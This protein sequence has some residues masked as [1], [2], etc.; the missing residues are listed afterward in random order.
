MEQQWLKLVDYGDF[1]HADGIQRVTYDAA[2]EMQKRFRSL[3]ARLARKFG[4]IPIY[5]GHPDDRHF[6]HLPGHHDT[7]SYAWVQDLEAREDGIWILPKWSAAGEEI[8]KNAFFK[9]LSPRW[10]MKR[11]GDVLVPIR[12]ISVGLTNHPNIPGE[13]I[14][15]AQEEPE[16]ATKSLEKTLGI[17]LQEP[18][19]PEKIVQSVEALQEANQDLQAESD[20]FYKLACEQEAKIKELTAAL[21]EAKIAS[22][23]HFVKFALERGLILPDEVDAWKERYIADPKTASNELLGQSLLNTHSKTE[24][25][26]RESVDP[27]AQILKRVQERMQIT[28][29][30]YT[31]AWHFV[32][33]GTPAF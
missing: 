8:L 3:R 25:L 21:M 27:R 12:L 1:P 7:R 32:R 24:H 15:N 10:E 4:G 29:E 19:W 31:A 22:G 13:A 26:Q 20:R 11:E 17:S 23:E 28:G 2:R 9:F 6:A 18:D 33:Q 16:V 14:A 5:I 30:D